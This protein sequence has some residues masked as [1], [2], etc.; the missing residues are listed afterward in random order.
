MSKETEPLFTREIDLEYSFCN[1]TDAITLS[2]KEALALPDPEAADD[3][4][5]RP[6]ISFSFV[7]TQ[8]GPVY[9]YDWAPVVEGYGTDEDV[10]QYVGTFKKGNPVEGRIYTSYAIDKVTL[11]DTAKKLYVYYANEDA[12]KKASNV[13]RNREVT[14]EK[15]WDTKLTGTV[16][17]TSDGQRLLFTIPY[18]AGWQLKVDGNKI[19]LERT[20]DLF[21]SAELTKGAH[22]YELVYVVP[23]LKVGVALS[24]LAAIGMV[25]QVVI[26]SLRSK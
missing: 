17:A 2:E 18:D 5:Y 13:L 19:E 8:D 20:M 21:M 6:Y 22:S 15:E 7:A 3:D 4:T 1:T 10:L 16:T 9:F 23:G 14:I 26:Y 11:A 24:V 25:I 12:L